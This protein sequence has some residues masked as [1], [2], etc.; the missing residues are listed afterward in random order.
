MVEAV[1]KEWGNSMGIILP[2]EKLKEL[3]LKKGDKIEIDLLSKKKIDA[4]GIAKGAKPFERK[5]DDRE[6]F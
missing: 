4:F 1:L 3:N 5:H 6:E 2:A